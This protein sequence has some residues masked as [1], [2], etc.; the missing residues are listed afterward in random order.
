MT[1]GI[2]GVY[3]AAASAIEP[4]NALEGHRSSCLKEGFALSPRNQVD[5]STDRGRSDMASKKL[6]NPNFAA[7]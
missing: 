7:V 2:A 1:E 4:T 6:Q 3:G 5:I